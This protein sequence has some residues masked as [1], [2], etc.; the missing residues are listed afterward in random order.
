[1]ALLAGGAGPGVQP[2]RRGRARRG[3]ADDSEPQD[4]Q[5]LQPRARGQ[6]V[7]LGLDWVRHVRQNRGG[8]R[9]GEDW[10]LRHQHLPRFRLQGD[11]Q[12]A[13][14]VAGVDCQGSDV[15]GSTNAL[16]SVT[17]HQ[18]ARAARQVHP[19]HNQRRSNQPDEGRGG[20]HQHV[21]RRARGHQG[22]DPRA[23]VQE[24]WRSRPGRVRGGRRVVFRGPRGRGAERRH[25]HAAGE[26]PQRH[27]QRPPSVSDR[28]GT[29]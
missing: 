17:H 25:L 10:L 27:P 29:G 6:P 19:P 7:A 5:S 26:L 18:P 8:H 3:S 13:L 14:A 22:S 28:G 4:P 21:A 2:L 16:C 23:Q 1:M 9:N 24:D 20:D 12:L 15:C 11:C